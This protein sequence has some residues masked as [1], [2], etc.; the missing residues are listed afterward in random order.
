VRLLVELE[1]LGSVAR[2]PQSAMSASARPYSCPNVDRVGDPRL[3]RLETRDF[4]VRLLQEIA[5]GFESEGVVAHH[6]SLFYGA[7][8]FYWWGA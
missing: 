6:C 8:S 1:V 4:T 5:W 3:E 7:P 2:A